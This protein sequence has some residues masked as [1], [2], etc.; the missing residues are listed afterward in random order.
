MRAVRFRLGAAA[1]I[2]A[3]TAAALSGCGSGGGHTDA[4]GTTR[5]PSATASSSSSSAGTMEPPA[6]SAPG[7]G[8]DGTTE[9]TGPAGPQK[10]L[11]KA[12]LTPATGTFTDS[13]RDYLVGRVPTGMDPSAVLQTGQESCDRIA[14]T[15]GVDPGAAREAI[16]SGQIADA[17]GA[18]TYLCPKYKNLL[19]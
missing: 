19:D 13:Q 11:P 3:A 5:P 9:S 7:I 6:A 14:T 8:P 10:T 2:V 1:V 18:I 15:A 17:K 16:K 12:Q 4:R